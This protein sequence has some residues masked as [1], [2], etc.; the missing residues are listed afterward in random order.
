[1]WQV[2]CSALSTHLYLKKR[3]LNLRHLKGPFASFKSIGL[4]RACYITSHGH[5]RVL[6]LLLL[7]R[8]S[9]KRMA[10]CC[11][12][13]FIRWVEY[14]G[15]QN[16]VMLQHILGIKR[17]YLIDCKTAGLLHN[18]W[19]N[20]DSSMFLHRRNVQ[21]WKIHNSECRYG[22]IVGFSFGANSKE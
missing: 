10:N 2:K 12:T 11:L 3:N 4:Q 15:R 20:V 8:G 22:A 6:N 19:W 1:M 17:S 14:K 16:F 9:K 5:E 21:L 13:L 7:W 18:S